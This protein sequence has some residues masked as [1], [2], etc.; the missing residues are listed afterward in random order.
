M[1]MTAG[2]GIAMEFRCSG[3]F[4]PTSTPIAIG[5]KDRAAAADAQAN[6]GWVARIAIKRP[7][8][9][10]GFSVGRRFRVDALESF[11]VERSRRLSHCPCA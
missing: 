10:V 3:S 1:P 6:S 11:A 9:N 4:M 2:I 7:N 8:T 5:R